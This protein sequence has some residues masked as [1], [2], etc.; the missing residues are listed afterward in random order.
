MGWAYGVMKEP[1]IVIKDPSQ[2]VYLIN[3][4]F[5]DFQQKFHIISD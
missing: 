4:D 1:D 5:P 2:V 3:T